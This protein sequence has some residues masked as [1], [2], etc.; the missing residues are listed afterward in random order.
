MKM[1]KRK[2]RIGELAKHL[3]VKSSVIRFWEKEFDSRSDRSQ[4]GQRFYD[5]QDLERFTLIKGLLYEKKFT[6]EGARI[7]IQKSTSK[8]IIPS[9]RTYLESSNQKNVSSKAFISKLLK[10][11]DKLQKFRELL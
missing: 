7:E 5:N 11:R 3:E 6:I 1:E 10:F 4:G 2:F 9:K 8:K